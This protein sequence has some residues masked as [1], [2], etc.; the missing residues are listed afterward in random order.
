MSENFARMKKEHISL[1]L[2]A[3]FF[4]EWLLKCL[5]PKKTC[6][7]MSQSAPR[8]MISLSAKHKS[9][10]ISDV[11]GNKNVYIIYFANQLQFLQSDKF[12][13]ETPD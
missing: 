8:F 7:A 1:H 12:Q 9:D 4:S 13:V 2:Q 10:K 5:V 6:S 3:R 11:A